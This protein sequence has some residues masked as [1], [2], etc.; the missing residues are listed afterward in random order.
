[1]KHWIIFPG[2]IFLYFSLH[3]NS[4]LPDNG[5]LFLLYILHLLLTAIFFHFFFF[6]ILIQ[7]NDFKESWQSPPMFAWNTYARISS[8]S[9][10]TSWRNEESKANKINADHFWWRFICLNK[11]RYDPTVGIFILMYLVVVDN[12]SAICIWGH[13]KIRVVKNEMS[14]KKLLNV[15]DVLIQRDL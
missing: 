15:T 2:F 13:Q 11:L 1:M 10:A 8:K 6:Q 3:F 7:N 12:M 9:I 5:F 4:V 14:K